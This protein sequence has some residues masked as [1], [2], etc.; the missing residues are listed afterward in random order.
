MRVAPDSVDTVIFVDVDGIV[1]SGFRDA[2]G[3]TVALNE[4]NVAALQAFAGSEDPEFEKLESLYKR[5]LGR[6]EVGATFAKVVA[7][8]AKRFS[9]VLVGRLAELIRAAGHRSMIVLSSSW[10]LPQ[11]D[12]ILGVL[13]QDISKHLGYRFTFDARTSA[14]MEIRAG[15]RLRLIGDFVASLCQERSS[16]VGRLKVLIL[17]DFMITPLNGWTVDGDVRGKS[18]KMDTREAV[19]EYIKRRAP[20]AELAVRLIHPYAEWRSEKS[21]LLVQACVGLVMEHF[22]DAAEFLGVPVEIAAEVSASAALAAKL[23]QTITGG[24]RLGRTKRGF[25]M[26]ADAIVKCFPR[27]GST[28][29]LPD[30]SSAVSTA[31][32]SAGSD[33]EW[34][35]ESRLHSVCSKEALCSAAATPAG[36]GGSA[37]ASKD[38]DTVIFVDIDG[39]LNAGIRDD[40]SGTLALDDRNVALALGLEGTPDPGAQDPGVLKLL[41]M[42]HRRLGF[43]E[44]ATFEKFVSEV[45]T[46]VSDVFVARLAELIAAAGEARPGERRMVV[47]ASS[48]RLPQ[49]ES[50]VRALEEM[51]SQHLGAP[52]AFDASTA[53]TAETTAEDRLRNI[54]DFVEELCSLRGSTSSRLRVL[55]LDDFMITGR[56]SCDGAAMDSPEAMEKYL[57]RRASTAE[58]V[59][60]KVVHTYDEWATFQGVN[61]QACVGLTMQHFREA[62]AFLGATLVLRQQS[63]QSS[64][65]SVLGSVIQGFIVSRL[66]GFE[67]FSGAGT[68]CRG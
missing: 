30:V 38:T 61:V 36:G 13:E 53:I 27:K 17:E 25:P 26:S 6:G 32:T 12:E 8:T 47:L 60:V 9:D 37:E 29:S 67:A 40:G 49:Y 48:W 41:S 15:D 33:A 62:A 7:D 24:L 21:G 1:N 66:A 2:G 4:A 35:E 23:Q 64:A 57:L 54:G 3:S 22:R 44:D 20:S 34:Y 16:S 14:G 55:V 42:Y 31:S 39:V 18:V 51:I 63:P 5:P 58:E 43:G 68:L 46:K 28:D 11:Y 65:P 50:M 52:F 59:L 10:R 56:W 45:P 19:E